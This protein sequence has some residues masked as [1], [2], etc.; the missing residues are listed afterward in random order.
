MIINTNMQALQ[1]NNALGLHAFAISDNMKKIATGLKINSASD[2]P[3]NIGISEEMRNK[4]QS[5]NMAEQNCDYGI[6]MLQ[7]ADGALAEIQSILSRMNELT[8]QAMNDTYNDNDKASM[9]TEIET[10]SATIDS[11]AK[12]T[13]FNGIQLLKIDYDNDIYS[14]TVESDNVS[15]GSFL[16]S[17]DAANEFTISATGMKDGGNIN[18]VQ[19]EI[20]TNT[21]TELTD[22]ELSGS[23]TASYNSITGDITFE[24]YGGWDDGSGT[25]DFII[26]D[27]MIQEAW[28][29]LKKEL[30]ED[31]VNS[32]TYTL[33]NIE[34]TTTGTLQAVAGTIEG[35]DNDYIYGVSSNGYSN[36]SGS[37]TINDFNISGLDE[38]IT[39]VI[40]KET[41]DASLL[42]EGGNAFGGD[43]GVGATV[44]ENGLLTIYLANTTMIPSMEISELEIES[45]IKNATFINGA[46]SVDM[47]EVDFSGSATL[48]GQTSDASVGAVLDVGTVG[49]AVSNPTTITGGGIAGGVTNLDMASYTISGI[50]GTGITG[51]VFAEDQSQTETSAV[52]RVDAD[53]VLTITVSSAFSSYGSGLTTA[54]T[55]EQIQEAIRNAYIDSNMTNSVNLDS[56]KFKTADNEGIFFTDST[57]DANTANGGA[58]STVTS[59]D[60]STDGSFN[61]TE[62]DESGVN[63]VEYLSVGQY[64]DL[65]LR[66][67]SEEGTSIGYLVKDIGLQIGYTGDDFDPK[68]I[69]VYDMR[70]KSLD[71]NELKISTL[72]GAEDALDKIATATDFVS[73]VRTKYGAI[74]SR[75]EYTTNYIN[76]AVEIT[77]EAKSKITDTDMAEEMQKYSKNIMLRQAAQAIAAQ[78]NVNP[79]EAWTLLY[80]MEFSN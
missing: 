24:V 79:R 58:G 17:N 15:M 51:V 40:F 1:A 62:G 78:A 71:V 11:I 42:T 23:L 69:Q 68:S 7:T 48:S 74:Q 14:G 53:G 5:L 46:T 77:T 75:L 31:S 38:S 22:E 13:E 9:Q 49:T 61:I 54:V 37:V 34:I 12:S 28:E 76:S 27:A 16:F 30:L 29:T 2:D 66:S 39:G 35:L 8:L 70:S 64:D 73:Y 47:S 63:G 21:R 32:V 18:F 60:S 26:D 36:A 33:N 80:N 44:D 19:Q 43:F 20:N 72:D 41:T 57:A 56:A 50:S 3:A 10:L 45:A 52:A 59:Y 65:S 67:L 25:Y 4:I 6:S 55:D